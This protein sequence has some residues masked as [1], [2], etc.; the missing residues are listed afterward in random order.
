MI[1]WESR[2]EKQV[3]RSMV[4]LQMQYGSIG[5]AVGATLGYC[6]ATQG[7]KRVILSIGDGSFQVTAQVRTRYLAS[8]VLSIFEQWLLWN[9]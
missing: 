7:K 1:Q 6:A 8:A 3:L 4:C 9:V 5:W 2:E